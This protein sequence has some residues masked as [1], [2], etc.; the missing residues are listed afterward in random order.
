MRIEIDTKCED[1]GALDALAGLLEDLVKLRRA[2]DAQAADAAPVV[3]A[4]VVAVPVMPAPP[5]VAPRVG[6]RR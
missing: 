2:Q 3:A 5:K 4:P 6:L 1:V